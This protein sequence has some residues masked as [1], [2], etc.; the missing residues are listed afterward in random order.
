M[1]LDTTLREEEEEEAAKYANYTF[2]SAEKV[3]G[4]I[5]LVSKYLHVAEGYIQVN[6]QFTINPKILVKIFIPQGDSSWEEYFFQ[7]LI[8]YIH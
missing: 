3:R 1:T 7:R 8:P 4:K 6:A 2:A 5:T